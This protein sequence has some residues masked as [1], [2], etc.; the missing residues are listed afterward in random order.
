MNQDFKWFV[1]HYDEFQRKYGNSYLAIKDK[2]VLGVYQ[3]Y[4]DA[5]RETQK[6]EE[7]GAFIVQEVCTN[8]LAYLGCINSG[9][10]LHGF[11][12]KLCVFDD[13]AED[14][15]HITLNLG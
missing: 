13:Y 9:N 7:L 4:G 5:I 8:C 6:V 2:A 3:S 1:D 10:C 11:R 15:I 14:D 12:A